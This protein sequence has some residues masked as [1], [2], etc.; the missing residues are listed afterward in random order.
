MIESKTWKEFRSTGLAFF[1]NQILHA[2]GWCI[3]F[4]M[5]NG[6]VKSVFP[7]RTKYRGFD[8]RSTSESYAKISKYMKEEA[9]TLYTECVAENGEGLEI[10][11]VKIKVKDS[12][13]YAYYD[14]AGNKKFVRGMIFEVLSWHAQ[15]GTVRVSVKTQRGKR[16]YDFKRDQY[17]VISVE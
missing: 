1:I 15:T 17:S 11:R 2:F 10:P 7:A 13:S 4:N 9:E 5:E 14:E 16:G 12:V 8:N 3:V 6:E